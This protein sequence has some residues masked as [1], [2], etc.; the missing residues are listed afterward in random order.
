V[1]SNVYDTTLDGTKANFVGQIRKLV[2]H[3]D[4][5]DTETGI[6]SYHFAI[7]D[8]RTSQYILPFHK[9]KGTASLLSLV[10]VDGAGKRI[11]ELQN[12]GRYQVGIRA[13]NNVNLSREYWT[14]GVTVDTT[15]P[16]FS[17]VV[18]SFQVQ[19][20]T[21]K[22]GWE[23]VDN[24]SGIETVSWSLNTSPDVENPKNFTGISRN[25]TELFISGISFKLGQTYYVYFKAINKAG[26]STLFVSDGVV[27]DRTPPSAGRVSAD[28]V[29]PANYDGNPNVTSGASF[30]VKWS[31]FADQESG[32]RAYG[33]AVGSSPE[34]TKRLSNSFYRR[35]HFTGYYFFIFHKLP[36][37]G[38][39]SLLA[40]STLL[41]DDVNNWE[42]AV[43]THLVGKP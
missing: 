9:I 30:T 40:L 41:Q 29:V 27:I 14:P 31:G 1:C 38:P 32:V 22:I 23:L 16:V 33:W 2:A 34:R 8:L 12:G 13:T 24:E 26:R 5:S 4:C 17:K 3:F 37:L 15:P 43:R 19:S 42:Q 18:A 11:I 35:I 21:I 36:P 39:G 20:E 6:T 28:F 7:K 10:V 25:S